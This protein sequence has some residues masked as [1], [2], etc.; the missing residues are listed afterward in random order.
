MQLLALSMFLKNSGPF[1]L[2]KAN[3]YDGAG[4]VFLQGYKQTVFIVFS[5]RHIEQV[6]QIDTACIGIIARQ[7]LAGMRTSKIA[8]SIARKCPWRAPCPCP[9]KANRD[10]PLLVSL[11]PMVRKNAA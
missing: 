5:N 4:V 8:A 10:C 2:A 6:E 9:D 1:S 3:C 7:I 11:L